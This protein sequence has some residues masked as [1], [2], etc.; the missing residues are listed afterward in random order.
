M[1]S[2][3]VNVCVFPSTIYPSACSQ[4]FQKVASFDDEPDELLFQPEGNA[5]VVSAEFAV[6]HLCYMEP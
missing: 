4:F 5:F 3:D 2:M 6:F 1:T